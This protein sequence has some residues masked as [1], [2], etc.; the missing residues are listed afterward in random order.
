M[1]NSYTVHEINL[2][3]QYVRAD[4]ALGN[5]LFGA[6]RLLKMLILINIFILDIVLQLIHVDFFQCPMVVGLVRM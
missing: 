1:L 5:Y 4:F 6:V 2:W 3:A